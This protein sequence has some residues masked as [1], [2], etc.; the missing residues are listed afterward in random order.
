M[1]ELPVTYMKE[2]HDI[3]V[4][5]DSKDEVY[6]IVVEKSLDRPIGFVRLNFIDPV[7]R[8]VWLRFVIGDAK[9]FG[10]GLAR[11]ALRQVLQWLFA[12]QNINRVTLETYETNK[13]AIQFFEMF[14]F[15]QEG[16]IREGIYFDGEY[17]NIVALGLLRREFENR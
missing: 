1:G 8:N 7:A 6:L 12:E 11:D 2:E 3:S 10:K 15:K 16:L 4:A 5:R 17:Y 14:G 9:S 13:R